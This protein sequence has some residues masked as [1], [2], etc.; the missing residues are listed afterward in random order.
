MED[1]DDSKK[2][3]DLFAWSRI[4]DHLRKRDASIEFV[5]DT[6]GIWSKFKTALSSNPRRDNQALISR[7]C[8]ASEETKLTGYKTGAESGRSKP[9]VI[10]MGALNSGKSTLINTI[11]GTRNLLPSKELPCTARIT[12]LNYTDQKPFYQLVL[13]D[14]DGTDE[15]IPV[16]RTELRKLKIDHACVRPADLS[17]PTQKNVN[18]IL[19]VFID[20]EVLKTGIQIIDTP[21]LS[22]DDGLDNLVKSLVSKA[23]D[24]VA[25]PLIVYVIDGVRRMSLRDRVMIEW[26]LNELKIRVK[27]VFSKC[28]IS[29]ENV[30]MDS[31]EGCDVDAEHKSKFKTLQNDLELLYK[32]MKDDLRYIPNEAGEG[33][34]DLKLGESRWCS[35]VSALNYRRVKRKKKPIGGAERH[36]W[37]ISQYDRMVENT[38]AIL[39]ENISEQTKCIYEDAMFLL[40]RCSNFVHEETSN[41]AAYI[42]ASENMEENVR[43]KISEALA[44][45]NEHCP[46][47]WILQDAL[48]KLAMRCPGH[49]KLTNLDIML[50]LSRLDPELVRKT[51]KWRAGPCDSA[52][53]ISLMYVSVMD[54]LQGFFKRSTRVMLQSTLKGI[55]KSCGGFGHLPGVEFASSYGS[56]LKVLPLQK[57]KEKCLHAVWE[58]VE[59]FFQKQVYSEPMRAML[60]RVQANFTG[61]WLNALEPMLD[62]LVIIFIDEFLPELG[63]QLCQACGMVL[64]ETHE[65]FNSLLQRRVYLKS[66]PVSG[67]STTVLATIYENHL[68]EME[69]FAQAGINYII[70]GAVT[71]GPVIRDEPRTYN[72]ERVNSENPQSVMAFLLRKDDVTRAAPRVDSLDSTVAPV[73]NSTGLLP[74]T[75]NEQQDFVAGASSLRN[76]KSMNWR[77]TI[78]NLQKTR[79]MSPIEH[80]NLMKIFNYVMPSYNELLIVVERCQCNLATYLST[81]NPS[82]LT[83]YTIAIGVANGF[84]ALIKKGGSLFWG[85]SP[86]DIWIKQL[87][88]SGEIEHVDHIKICR[89]GEMDI[90][91]G[92]VKSEC[93]ISFKKATRTTGSGLQ[94]CSSTRQ[95]LTSLDFTSRLLGN[96]FCDLLFDIFPSANLKQSAPP[97]PADIAAIMDSFRENKITMEEA[98]TKIRKMR[99]EELLETGP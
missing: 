51:K 87:P 23:T 29:R 69:V 79:E 88:P 61:Y 57:F 81:H 82:L 99:D 12:R 22:E 40:H 80:D 1:T 46:V 36:V 14:I 35:C 68:V 55:V 97:I 52:N 32:Q 33:A 17:T 91:I 6:L 28:D 65:E 18:L 16:T 64:S 70:F 43:H 49:N 39:V 95:R 62:E 2:D 89:L 26:L 83:R 21:G 77:Q 92:R 86:A 84:V 44:I 37:F 73:F 50:N 59:K 56:L 5:S 15:I 74:L 38:V 98:S 67:L 30:E 45:F 4:L 48:K 24:H 3:R 71:L 13:S 85:Y 19:D 53:N 78:E 25:R 47:M 76:R 66:A 96:C 8:T 31:P 54:T 34:D 41:L 27:F 94:H 63:K 60:K 90:A 20:N 11:L 9:S 93:G 7:L 42:Y 72:I 10:F 75:N 58:T